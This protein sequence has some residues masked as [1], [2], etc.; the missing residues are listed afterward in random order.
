MQVGISPK[1]YCR[2]RRFQQALTRTGRGRPVDWSQVAL[3]CGYYDQ[4]HFIHEF[5]SF[6]GLTPT[7]YQASQTA[8][9]ND[10]KVL[11][12]KEGAV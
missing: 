7:G 9:Q 3:D 12:S 2:I 10:V 11:Q 8:F 6:S 5:R 4:A 1:R